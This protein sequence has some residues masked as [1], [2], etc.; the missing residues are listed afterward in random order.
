MTYI[1]HAD[2]PRP[3]APLASID[4]MPHDAEPHTAAGCPF[5]GGTVDADV[6]LLRAGTSR[7]TFELQWECP[8]CGAERTAEWTENP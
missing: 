2:G 4:T 5:Q 1:G 8:G 3:L 7:R 6:F